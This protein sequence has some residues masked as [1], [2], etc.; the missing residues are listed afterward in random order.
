MDE[1]HWMVFAETEGKVGYR[2]W[3]WVA[4]TRDTCVYLLEP[5]RSAEVPKNHLGQDPEGIISADRYVV[6]QKLGENIRVAFCWSH[7]RR[8]FLPIQAGYKRLRRWAEGWLKRID[9]LFAQNAKRLEVL[10]DP[11]AFCLED[12][13]LRKLVA[14]M[15][16]TRERELA[17]TT[18]HPAQR[19]LLESLREHWE[20]LI[21]FVDNPHIPMDN[22]EAERRLRNPVVGR[23]N[24]YGSGSLWSGMLSAVLFTILQTLIINNID[25]Q[26]FLTTY[27][28]ACAQ[29]GSQPLP[30]EA[31][32]RFLPW[33]LSEEQ[34]ATW[35]YPEKPP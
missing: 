6:Y 28:Q 22:N 12:Q 27:F 3:L 24:Y 17:N 13:A 10:G 4:V 19:K 32:K 18:W 5:T 30:D 35:W 11:E 9:D 34:K 14:A 15:G 20:G 33:N 21:L 8:D 7:V 1:T 29:N 31:L 2:W 26:K 16:E 23:K 25:P